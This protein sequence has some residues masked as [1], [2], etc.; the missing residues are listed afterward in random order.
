[1]RRLAAWSVAHR[2]VVDIFVVVLVVGGI[3]AFSE[4]RREF[5]P[6]ISFDEVRVE[7]LLPGATPEDVERL[8]T[9]PIEDE[10]VD[11][12]GVDHVESVS[13]EGRSEVRVFVDPDA[14]T[15]AEVLRDVEQ[16]VARAKPKLPDEAEEP[17]VLER[18]FDAP[19]IVAAILGDAP[20]SRRKRI[21]DRLED[22]IREIP[23]VSSV[24]VAGLRAREFVVEVDPERLAARGIS[25]SDVA[26]ALAAANADR[27]A[28]RLEGPTG[29]ILVRSRARL[30][31]V[32]AVRG[33][34]VRNTPAG[35]I[36]VADV[37]RVFE[38]VADERTRSRVN[39]KP[40]TILTVLKSKEGDLIEVADR[41]KEILAEEADSVGP[42]LSLTYVQDGSVWI[43][44]R[45][46]VAY[47]SGLWGSFLVLVLLAVFLDWE[48]AL[49]SAFGIPLAILGALLVMFGTGSTL[50]MLSIFG[51]IVVIGMLV[52]DA[53]VVVENVARYKEAG[54]PPGEAVVRGAAEVS[55]PVTAAVLTTM[56]AL[57]PLALMTGVLGKFMAEIPKP[58]IYAL[59][60]SLLEALVTLPAHLYVTAHWGRPRILGAP[61]A[62]WDRVRA[63]GDRFM[64]A[65]RRL[66]RRALGR[67]LRYRYLFLAGFVALFAFALFVE[68]KLHRFEL[69]ATNDMP[70][71]QVEI[72]APAG[73]G[74]DETERIVAAV[75]REVMGLPKDEVESISSTIGVARRDRGFEYGREI[76]Q[77][78]VDLEEPEVRPR[79]ADE[80]V[81]DLRPRLAGIRGAR[82]TVSE[83]RGGPPV[84]AP[85][86]VRLSGDDWEVLRE[87]SR[88]IQEYAAGLPGVTD[89][90]DDL[91]E[92][93]PEA[94]VV[95]DPVA[96]ALAG[97]TP[98]DVA[99][100]VRAAADGIEATSV[101]VGDEEVK[102]RVRYPAARRTR[103]EDLARMSL[104]TPAGPAPLA[105]LARVERGGGLARVRHYDGKR[106]VTATADIDPGG[107]ESREANARIRARFAAPSAA[108]GV[109]LALGGE[110]EDTAESLASIKWAAF[111]GIAL[112]AVILVF[113]FG[114]FVQ[115][116]AVLTALPGA[117]IGVIFALY[118]HTLVHRYTGFGLDAPMGLLPLIGLTALLGVIVNDA[119]LLVDF[120]NEAR[121]R[122]TNRWRAILESGRKRIRSVFLTS[123]T[124][125]AG[126][127]PMAYTARGSSAFLA[128]M[129]LAF[130]WGLLFGTLITVFV[131]PVFVAIL[132]DWFE[133]Y[134]D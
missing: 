132:D 58:G 25:S 51:F 73:T 65:L 61:L 83:M 33:V 129:G 77:V 78:M 59:A 110:H 55:R 114:N 12:P 123:V 14:A 121:R 49:W 62:A 113:E 48:S 53:I 97:L 29:E 101:R 99:A 31:T 26:R 2:G 96:T 94:V 18:K 20:W 126:V 66:H 89:V 111:V 43:R 100:E 118:G 133:L 3:Y 34:V 69:V 75:E 91:K 72:E 56:A 93:P 76:A 116:F 24:V 39:G 84:G 4:I 41:V 17:V 13:S 102:I 95:P 71:F 42:G 68:L 22:R 85:I 44:E 125:A 81:A 79:N 112:I 87:V 5:F 28:G 10:V 23:G 86:A 40:A 50:N 36:R 128:P 57:L 106:T 1:M 117:L 63:A 21:A 103:A 119:I 38:T 9:D 52:D 105:N 64:N 115:P 15:V 107:I 92:G 54:L 32:E 90:R 70:L 134:S 45:L 80:I 120:V 124:T 88:E 16:A 6:E 46:G 74:L 27:P 60:V 104:P 130:G 35:P 30:E 109:R 108:R 11:L 19:V 47:K 7:T 122:G 131:V 67:A 127:L 82:V 37:A 98:S 8:V